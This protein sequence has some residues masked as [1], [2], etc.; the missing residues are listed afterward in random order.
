NIVY[1]P[2]TGFVGHDSFTYTLSDGNGGTD[3]GTVCV[4]VYESGQWASSVDAV[5]SEYDGENEGEYAAEQALGA[6]NTFDFGDAA[7]SWAAAEADAGEQYITVAFTTASQATGV[8]IREANAQGFVME[9]KLIES[10]NTEHS[11]WTGTDPAEVG[12]P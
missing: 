6:P 10:N 11:I 4:Y 1:T 2:T 12:Y 9:V 8:I 5:S 7:T 3:T